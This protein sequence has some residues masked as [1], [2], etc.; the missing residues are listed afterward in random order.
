MR[1]GP[2]PDW[3][4]QVE[5]LDVPAD[6]RGLA[7]FR[8]QV[9]QV[10]LT[11]DTQETYMLQHV[12][13]LHPNALQMGNVGITWNPAAGTPTV[14]ALRIH[15]DGDAIDVL[16]QVQF[17]VLRR[18]DQLE[19]AWID[20][21]LTATLQVP[22]L[23]V[24]DDLE[25]AFTLP[26]GNPS[27]PDRDFGLMT[28]AAS[29]TPGRINMRVSWEEDTDAP[30]IRITDDLAQFA[31]REERAVVIAADSADAVT[32]PRD[33]P[34]RYNWQ[35]VLEF[36]DFADWRSVSNRFDRLFD[37]ARQIDD[38]SPVAAEAARIAR[39]HE[40]DMA[41]ARAALDLVTRQVRYIFVGLNTGA[42]TPAS[43][44]ET[45]E[46]RY[47]DC[48][49]KTALLLSLLD[50]LGIPAEA[51]LVNN[52]GIDDA[53]ADLLPTPGA[54]DHVLVRAT[55]DGEQYWMDG[56]LPDVAVPTQR[57]LFPYSHVLPLRDGGADLETLAWQPFDAPQET[58]LYEIDARAG[59]ESPAKISQTIITR[60]LS[61]VAQY[62]TLSALTEQQLEQAWR[63]ELAGST[64][65]DTVESVDWRFDKEAQA[66]IL[67]I[68]GSGM[69]DWEDEGG[70]AKQLSLVGGG[71]YPPGRKQRDAGQDQSAPFWSESL[72]DCNVTTVRIPEDT[73]VKQ[74]SSNTTYDS[75]IYGRVDRRMFGA[76]DG[77]IRMIRSSYTAKNEIS[78]EQAQ[79]DNARLANFDNSQAWIYYEPGES[80]RW[81]KDVPVPATYERDWVADYSPC[82]SDYG[83]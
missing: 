18:E 48:K 39:A 72:W 51:V 8:K 14:H 65:W 80:S 56:T 20:G 5:A 49:G 52:T 16:D 17:E 28:M 47:G 53:F 78:P 10:H 59:F 55:I 57:A 25:M 36:T 7:F 13:L 15:R 75:Q 46:R 82:D 69:P 27:L 45:W 76:G 31:T 64:T 34:P 70:G 12:R 41:R 79:R 50:E 21:L 61:A 68:T 44:A 9:T 4:E 63:A 32:P 33:A 83:G 73:S 81:P 19:Q 24:G 40:T 54:F 29:P 26:T 62:A 30:H 60:G 3:V 22:D 23:R 71:L 35:R 43:A 11:R 1:I 66:S 38:G 74:W 37:A 58:V 2:A 6:A 42:L 67:I 77:A